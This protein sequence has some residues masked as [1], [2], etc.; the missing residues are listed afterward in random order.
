M[1]AVDIIRLMRL[2]LEQGTATYAIR[3]Y[4]PGYV[5]VN[6]ERITC[7]VLVAPE[8]LVRDW[9]PTSFD[10][11]R[12]EHFDLISELN[13]EV[14]LLGTGRQL[15]FPAADLT[16]PLRC[17]NIGL[18]VMDTAAACRSYAVLMAEGRL[19]I[20]ALLMIE[21]AARNHPTAIEAIAAKD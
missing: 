10:A 3:D 16:A 14:V 6:T 12:K 19:V 11:L 13:P 2:D 21:S 15:R 1:G 4:G 8:H 18:E 5:V 17:K 9:P 7:S 20:A